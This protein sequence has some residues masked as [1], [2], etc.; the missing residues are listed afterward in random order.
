MPINC[1]SDLPAYDVLTREGVYG[2]GRGNWRPRQ[3]IRR[4]VLPCSTSCPRKSRRN[5]LPTAD[6]GH[7]AANRIQALIR[8]SDQPVRAIPAADHLEKLPYRPFEE[9]TDENSTVWSS[10]GGAESNKL[11][12]NRCHLLEA[13]HTASLIGRKPMSIST[14]GG[15][16]WAACAMILFP[17]QSK[18]TCWKIKRSG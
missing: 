15:M 18:N 1:P 6:S 2:A 11:D 4:C 13:A 8:M 17:R 7:T 14:L 9:V 3:D 12:F 10:P 16:N 5:Q